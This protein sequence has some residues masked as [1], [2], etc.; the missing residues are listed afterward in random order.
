MAEEI[1][2]LDVKNAEEEFM[3]THGLQKFRASEYEV[4]IW[5]GM[6]GVFEDEVPS[7]GVWI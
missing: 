7:F 5:E 6:G 1:T 3:M 4:E 2:G